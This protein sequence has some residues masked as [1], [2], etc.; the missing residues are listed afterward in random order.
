MTT[1]ETATQAYMR[2]AAQ[3]AANLARLAEKLATHLEGQAENPRDWGYVG[4]LTYWNE[5]LSD[6]LN[7][8]EVDADGT[9]DA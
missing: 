7:N 9:P 2:Q 5:R 6:I 1:T 3:V 4:D 8:P